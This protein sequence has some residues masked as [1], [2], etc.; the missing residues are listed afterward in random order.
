MKRPNT[1]GNIHGS[2]NGET[3]RWMCSSRSLSC[4]IQNLDLLDRKRAR[5]LPVGRPP[6]VHMRENTISASPKYNDDVRKKQV[7]SKS[8]LKNLLTFH[9]PSSQNTGAKVQD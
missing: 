4:Y 1:N 3:S 7:K 2:L 9:H 8:G 5:F 6:T